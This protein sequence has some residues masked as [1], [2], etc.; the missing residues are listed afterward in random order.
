MS[1]PFGKRG[2]F[3]ECW[4]HGGPEWMRMGVRATECP[5]IKPAF[6]ERER[7]GMGALWFA[8]EYMGEFVD[9]GST[10]FGSGA[11]EKAMDDGVELLFR[12]SE[13]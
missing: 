4:E 12:R 3:Y 9:N 5:R 6:L 11:V 1:T 8:Q 7:R 2:F 13:A 10:L